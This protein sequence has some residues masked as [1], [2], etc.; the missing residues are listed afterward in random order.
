[1][2]TAYVELA[3]GRVLGSFFKGTSEEACEVACRIAHSCVRN[4]MDVLCFGF[5]KI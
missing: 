1:M 2:Y 4:G 5:K 3:D